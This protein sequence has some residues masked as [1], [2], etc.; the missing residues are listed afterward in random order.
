[1]SDDD[2][3]GPDGG[4]PAATVGGP[5]ESTS[6]GTLAVG[7]ALGGAAA[8]L[9]RPLGVALLAAYLFVGLAGTVATS[10]LLAAVLPR[11][12]RFVVENSTTTA[13]ELPP[14]E[15]GPLALAVSPGVAAGLL[16]A[17]ALV[18]ETLNVFA[19]RTFVR[20]ARSL[21]EGA[22]D[23]LAARAAASFVANTL[24]AIAI[25]AGLV[26]FL[27]PGVFLAVAFYLVRA[28]VAVEGAGVVPALRR[29]WRLTAGH[30]VRVLLVLLFVLVVGQV[31]TLPATT[32]GGSPTAEAAATGLGVVLGALVAAFAAA[33]A[34]RV[35]VQL[36]GIDA[37]AA[38]RE[39]DGDPDGE[40]ALGALSP[41]EIDER[42]GN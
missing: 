5:D 24:A 1:V 22:F 4:D 2:R 21:P 20:D 9:G 18:A 34:A 38:A 25:F 40:E 15:P 13:A 12:R 17:T 6:D 3:D 32:L 42:F 33:V 39:A 7:T 41:E 23:G 27:V 19:I 11:L 37:A 30:R 26:A 28:V 31:T 10:S 35:Y 14:F 16:L 36:A 29:S 8:R